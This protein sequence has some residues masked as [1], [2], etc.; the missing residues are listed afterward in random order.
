MFRA[1]IVVVSAAAVAIALAYA[2]GYA[3]G[4]RRPPTETVGQSEVLLRSLDLSNELDST[5]GRPLRMRKITLQPGGVLA[6]H[7]HVDRPAITYLLQGQ[8]TYHQEGKPDLVANPG[9]GFAE[10]RATTHWGESTGTVPAV[11]IAVD[12]PKP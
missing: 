11:W 5:R 7:N 2:T 12:I 8:M 6:V 9:D 3:A 10:G 1:P 4:Q